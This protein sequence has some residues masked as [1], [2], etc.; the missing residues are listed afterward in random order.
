M[1]IPPNRI[2]P[3]SLGVFAVVVMICTTSC[4]SRPE[5]DS[6]KLELEFPGSW[7][8][9]SD[10]CEP[11]R[12]W[13]TNFGVAQLAPLVDEAL[14]NNRDLRVAVARL[15]AGGGPWATRGSGPLAQPPVERRCQPCSSKLHRLSQF[16]RGGVPTRFAEFHIDDIWCIAGDFVGDR[17][18]GE[19]SNR[20][21]RAAVASAQAAGAD[22]LAARQSLAA[23]VCKAWFAVRR[24]QAPTSSSRAEPLRASSRPRRWFVIAMSAVCVLPSTCDS[25]SI[26]SLKPR[27]LEV[28]RRDQLQESKRA[29]ELPSRPLSE[30][31][32]RW[33]RCSSSY[34]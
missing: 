25:R 1:M 23:Q 29:L 11:I 21:K 14:A 16:R 12:E 9:E 27:A 31:E 33:C 34:T 15:D 2:L 3:W 6:S 26:N 28:L 30:S 5:P 10:G 8:T 17:S 32:R 22:L 19:G 13:W 7:S 20:G 18:M 24:I 4:A